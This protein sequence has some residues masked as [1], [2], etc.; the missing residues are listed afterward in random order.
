MPISHDRIHPEGHIL[1]ASPLFLGTVGYSLKGD[2]GA[3][4]CHLL[5]KRGL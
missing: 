4:P 2:R 3:A 5:S 1:D